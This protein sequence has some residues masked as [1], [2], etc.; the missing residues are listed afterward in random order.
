MGCSERK[1]EVAEDAA[2]CG[3]MRRAFMLLINNITQDILL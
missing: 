2:L 3:A 1:I